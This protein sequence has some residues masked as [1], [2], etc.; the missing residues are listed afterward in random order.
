MYRTDAHEDRSLLLLGHA[1]KLTAYRR[2]SGEIAWTFEDSRAY[3]YY[4]DFV[5]AARRVYVAV[6]TY[7]AA[8]D[9]ATGRPLFSTELPSN[10]LRILL[11]EQRLYA[12]G[13]DHVWCVELDGRLVWQRE[14]TLTTL[15]TMP[16]YGFPGNI[17]NGFR[18][19]G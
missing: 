10:V 3:G 14:H 6:G 1:R 5:I 15:D 8:L 11:D 9:Y 2:E 17:V 18:D 12:F 19:N 4:V 16:T 7:V 13:A